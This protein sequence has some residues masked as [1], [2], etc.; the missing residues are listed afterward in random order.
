[1]KSFSKWFENRKSA[2]ARRKSPSRSRVSV[3]K[4][5]SREVLTASPLPVLMVIADQ[6]DFYYKE[7]GDTRT[8]L[9]AAGLDVVVAAT[10]TNTSTPH[11]GSGQGAG[12]GQVVPD[13]AL[14]LANADDYSAIV[15]VG[16]WGS[17]MYQYAYN[18]PN[19]DGVTDNYYVNPHYNGD[20]NLDDGVIAPQKVAANELIN[21]F[22]AQDKPVAAICHAT[23]VLAWARVAGISPLS[24]KH[25][26]VPTTV[27]SPDQFYLNQWRNAGYYS[28]Q[29]D[30]LIDNGAI[31]SNVT[32]SIGDPATDTD[33]VVVD[34]RIITGENFNSAL[35]FGEVIADEVLADVVP[36]NQSPV[37]NN[38]AWNLNENS[39]A[40]TEVGVVSASDPDVGQSLTYSIVGGNIN[41][42][43]A[44]NPATGALTVANVAAIDFEATPVF[45]LQIDVADNGTPSLH[46]VAQVTVNLNNLADTSVS[47]IG[48]DLFVTGTSA[49]DV[50]YIWSG[51]QAERVM[52]HMNGVGYG[53]YLLPA[54]GQ[55]IVHGGQGNDQIYA[56]DTR[57]GV[58]IYGDGGHDQ[59]TGGTAGD[60]LDGGGGVDR[61][62]G[63]TGNDFI[64]GGAGNDFLYGREGDNVLVGGEGNDTL[65]G[66]DGRD[67]LIGGLGSDVMRGAGGEDLLIGGTTSY[68]TNQASL[69]AIR[70]LWLAPGNID[71]RIALLT[72]PTSSIRLI[73]DDTVQNDNADDVMAGQG[74]ADWYFANLGDT[75]YNHLVFDRLAV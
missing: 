34:G 2:S 23:T 65:E 44:I 51:H 10:T 52:V 38:A 61:V 71:A 14:G 64:F 69:T 54:G 6:Q 70:D 32:G 24:G 13:I 8:S 19:A 26:A 12:S 16:G 17:S 15:F 28:G 45:N 35:Y 4:L 21:D 3:E 48:D 56:T 59:I 25:V 1:M 74:G 63:G 5:E 9:E 62:W 68:D 73:H 40:G 66:F 60:R 49:A 57:I 36:D 46:D 43:F 47:Q 33:D 50:I 55:V 11:P 37:A 53:N 75:V 39:P 58:S 41:N 27:S 72:D 20:A 42:A 67:V 29:Y 7:Y 18:D 30:Q 31:A 22:L